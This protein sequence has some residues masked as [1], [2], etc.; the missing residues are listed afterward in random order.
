MARKYSDGSEEIVNLEVDNCTK[1]RGAV[2]SKIQHW[3][4]SIIGIA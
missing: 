4:L 3:A 1:C 2:L